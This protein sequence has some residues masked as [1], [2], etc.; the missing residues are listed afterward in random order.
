MRKLH[1]TITGSYLTWLLRHLWI[2]GNETKAV[3]VWVAAFP[4]LAS[5]KII[6]NQFLDVVSGRKK[7]VGDNSYELVD[8]GRK[9]WDP[10]D[11]DGEGSTSFPLLQS[12]EDV[13]LLK[14]V[15]FYFSEMNLRAGT[16]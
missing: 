7:F 5:P 15:K 16:R 8:D 12:W 13:I 2:E 1:F 14:K 9:Y 10:E 6:K 11:E 3:N 4:S